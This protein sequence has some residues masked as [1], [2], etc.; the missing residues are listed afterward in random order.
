MDSKHYAVNLLNSAGEKE[1]SFAVNYY[2][3]WYYAEKAL[4][5]RLYYQHMFI[6]VISVLMYGKPYSKMIF[7]LFQSY[8]K[9]CE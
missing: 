9:D 4:G 8:I 7:L 1:G 5:L 3:I 6:R 2:P